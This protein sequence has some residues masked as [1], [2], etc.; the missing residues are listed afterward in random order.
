M[1]GIE[2][3]GT[4]KKLAIVLVMLVATSA[5]SA[6]KKPAKG[7]E[8][9]P[10]AAET[11]GSDSGAEERP[12]MLSI[13]LGAVV[14]DA[15]YPIRGDAALLADG[16]P[17]T[18]ITTHPNKPL[19]LNIVV[20]L[21]QLTRITSVA[22]DSSLDDDK[23]HPGVSARTVELWASTT[24]PKGGFDKVATFDLVRHGRTPEKSLPNP[25]EARWVKLIITE[26]YG[27][28]EYTNLKEVELFGEPAE[29][30]ETVNF[31]GEWSS[32][33]GPMKIV[34]RGTEAAGCGP[35]LTFRGNVHGRA[36]QA[37]W[38]STKPKENY[39][40]PLNLVMVK[41]DKIVGKSRRDPGYPQD[42]A[43][44]TITPPQ[45]PIILDCSVDLPGSMADELAAKGRIALYGIRFAVDSDVPLPESEP[46]LNEVLAALQAKP[47]LKLMVEG[48]T[49][50]TASAAHNLD[51]SLRRAKSVV[52]WLVE[53][54][55]DGKR[56]APKGFGKNNPVASNDTADGRALNRRVEIAV[57]P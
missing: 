10:V 26:N 35:N 17:T 51:L 30:I 7:A 33:W 4:M 31:A 15:P 16:N 24:G 38:K 34:Q 55:I 18:G 40:G 39:K 53:H 42:W 46:T 11:K 57:L 44:L 36:L 48:H 47:A 52:K 32:N 29:K 3:G 9:K 22:F 45:K 54:A 21:G 23:K 6:P 2:S 41:P 12:N 14:L 50:A 5:W 13:T 8:A 56:L 37:V 20:E 49:D 27:S 1:T 43:W 19:P 25:V 28:K